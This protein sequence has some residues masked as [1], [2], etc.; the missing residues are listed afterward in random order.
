MTKG[1]LVQEEFEYIFSEFKLLIDKKESGSITSNE[2]KRMDEIDEKL[3]QHNLR[4]TNN[5]I[6]DSG[7]ILS[8]MPLEEFRPIW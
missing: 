6:L 4:T 3:V 2:R 7:M 5:M 8:S 1:I